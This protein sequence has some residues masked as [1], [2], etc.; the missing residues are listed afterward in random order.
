MSVLIFADQADGQ[1]KKSSY[2]ALTYGA[3]VAEMLGVDAEALVLG[4]VNS[5]LALLG[6]YGVKK[7]HHANNP[8]LN[9]ADAQ[10]YT[11]AIAEAAN[12]TGAKVIVFSNNITA[13]AVAPR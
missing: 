8:E 6:K 7:V 10:V 13:R 4:A 11:K 1:L 5:D 3:K 9:N 12:A 2:E